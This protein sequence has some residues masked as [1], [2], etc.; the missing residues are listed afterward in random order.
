MAY[1]TKLHFNP[2]PSAILNFY[3]ESRLIWQ[4]FV[5]WM[6]SVQTHFILQGALSSR[7]AN[8]SRRPNRGTPILTSGEPHV[9]QE[10]PDLGSLAMLNPSG[11][12]QI[13]GPR[14]LPQILYESLLWPL[15]EGT[16]N[17]QPPF[18]LDVFG[19]FFWYSAPHWS[20]PPGTRS[21]M[22]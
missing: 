4:T 13:H 22:L 21:R 14:H 18:H 7:P 5:K 2:E 10:A 15:P 11:H 17:L 6:I 20:S 12:L 3:R 16:P 8:N 9:D 1:P 19:E